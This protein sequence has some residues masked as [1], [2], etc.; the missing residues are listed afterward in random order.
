[1]VTRPV[2]LNDIK[3]RIAEALVDSDDHA[4]MVMSWILL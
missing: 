3:G 2:D 1:M 4:S